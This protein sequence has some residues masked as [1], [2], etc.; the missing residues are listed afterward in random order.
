MYEASH[1]GILVRIEV[2]SIA[3]VARSQQ[4]PKQMKRLAAVRSL[5]PQLVLR[6][7]SSGNL[8]HSRSTYRLSSCLGI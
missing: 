4:M 3:A 8:A 6:H 7:L 1:R 2:G 5:L